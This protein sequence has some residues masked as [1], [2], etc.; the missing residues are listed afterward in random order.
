MDMKTPKQCEFDDPLNYIAGTG[1]YHSNADPAS[2]KTKMKNI[3]GFIRPAKS[4]VV[5]KRRTK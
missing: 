5:R 4:K 2:G 3:I 1:N